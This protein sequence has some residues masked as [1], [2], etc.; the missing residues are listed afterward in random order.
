[1]QRPDVPKRVCLAGWNERATVDCSSVA[2]GIL[3]AG[4]DEDYVGLRYQGKLCDEAEVFNQ[5]ITAAASK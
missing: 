5:G 4:G 2:D 1:M 3:K